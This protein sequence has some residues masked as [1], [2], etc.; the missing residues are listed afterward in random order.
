MKFKMQKIKACQVLLGAVLLFLQSGCAVLGQFAGKDFD[1]RGKVVMPDGTQAEDVEL[2]VSYGKI[3]QTQYGPDGKDYWERVHSKDGTFHIRYW[4]VI[5]VTIRALKPGYRSNI[6]IFDIER[7]TTAKDLV[8]ELVEVGNW[9]NPEKLYHGQYNFLLDPKAKAGGIKL[10]N[11]RL[12]RGTEAVAIEI[13]DFFFERAL[14]KDAEGKEVAGLV[15][16]SAAGFGARRFSVPRQPADFRIGLDTLPIPPADGYQE[17]IWLPFTSEVKDLRLHVKTP[18]GKYGRLTIREMI[19]RKGESG[20]P[21]IEIE[22]TYLIQPDG[23][24]NLD[25]WVPPVRFDEKGKPIEW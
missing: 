17:E 11:Q 7:K 15:F 12:F 14:K 9:T 19:V 24:R 16:K 6:Y 4:R 13:A 18:E 20:E 1:I 10:R 25:V 21:S 2:Y 3:V 23:S 22:V 8:V 5:D